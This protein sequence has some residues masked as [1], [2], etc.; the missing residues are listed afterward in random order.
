M[1]PRG[2]GL[3]SC[4]GRWFPPDRDRLDGVVEVDETFVGGRERGKRTAGRGTTNKAAVAIAVEL[5]E[6]KG[7]GRVRLAHLREVTLE[8]L[9]GFVGAT[10]TAGATVRTDGWNVYAP[11]AER[12][13]HESVAISRTGHPAHVALPGVHRVA[14]LL[15]RWLTGTLHYGYSINQFDY[16]LDEFTFRFNRRTARSRDLL[17][18][19]LLQQA[20]VTDPHPYCD[21]T[22]SSNID[23][24]LWP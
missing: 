14:S 13:G 7:L 3:T 8:S 20:V 11:L 2:L 22:I 4:A 18:Y 12:F 23:H 9:C 5:L 17:F 24:Y 1:R 16:Y 21:L 19:R 15:K 6:P 10:V